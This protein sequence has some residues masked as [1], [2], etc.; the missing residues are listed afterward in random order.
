MN[1]LAQAYPAPQRHAL[2]RNADLRGAL[3]VA[4]WAFL[5]TCVFDP[6]DRLLGIKVWIFALCWLLAAFGI[7]GRRQRS[8]LPPVLLAYT[9]TFVL[10]PFLSIAWYMT[11]NGAQPFEGFALFKGYL[12]IT[13]ALL[14]VLSRVDLLRQLSAVLTLLALIVI[15]VFI[16]LLVQPDLYPVIA[17]AG[18]ATGIVSLDRRDYGSDVV[19]LQVYFVT[20]PMLAVSIAYYFDRAMWAPARAAKL[21]ALSLMAI[22]VAGMLLAGTRN[23]IVIALALP[24]ALWFLHSRNRLAGAVVSLGLLAGLLVFFT[25]ELRAFFDPSEVSNNV[26]LGLVND[27]WKLFEDPIVLLFGQGLGAYQAW[28]AKGTYDYITEL[29]YFEMVRNFG[30]LGAAVMLVLLLYPIVHA[31]VLDRRFHAKTIVVA[32]AF[33]LVMCISNPNLFSSMGILI[34]SMILATIHLTPT[35]AAGSGVRA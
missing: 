26:K 34:L 25:E 22:S 30:L 16:A 15:G 14:L 33:Y 3:G 27:Y 32:Y 31:F 8:A 13:L 5:L 12:L 21:R 35:T 17:V 11:I 29:T 23:N 18:E 2:D 6:A 4:L 28:A 7:A 10:V 9:L 19:L 1:A 24:L 20:S